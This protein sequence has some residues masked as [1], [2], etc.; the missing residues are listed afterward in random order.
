MKRRLY[1]ILTFGSLV[2]C[3]PIC[4]FWARSWAFDEYVAWMTA[5][6]AF[7]RLS[8]D[9]AV[10]FLAIPIACAMQRLLHRRRTIAAI[11]AQRLTDVLNAVTAISSNTRRLMKHRLFT[12]LCV[13]VSVISLSLCLLTAIFWV[14]DV[15]APSDDD[16][17]A[18]NHMKVEVGIDRG[19]TDVGRHFGQK[20]SGC[21]LL[22][23]CYRPFPLPIAGPVIHAQIFPDEHGGIHY[24]EESRNF[25]S[26]WMMRETTKDAGIIRFRRSYPMEFGIPDASHN[27]FDTVHG[28][29]D[30]IVIPFWVITLLA[31]ITGA[32]GAIAIRRALKGRRLQ[33]V[34]RC[35][36]CGYDLRASP[37]RCPECG[38]HRVATPATMNDEAMDLLLERECGNRRVATA[39]TLPVPSPGTPGEG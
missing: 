19:T 36:V 38:N 29:S 6:N 34:G 18:S 9:A 12:I 5:K 24:S 16:L 32:G 1:T 25:Q 30:V 21:A 37:D 4:L 28:V 31:L 26:K 2:L 10:V 33:R 22:F 17:I 39:A 23:G 27:A 3:L 11:F 14:A 15:E 8:Q 35:P 13:T 20:S 7:A